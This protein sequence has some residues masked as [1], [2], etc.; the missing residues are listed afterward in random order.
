[1]WRFFQIAELWPVILSQTSRAIFFGSP[2]MRVVP[3]R[4]AKAGGELKS[5]RRWCLT[6][7]AQPE[8]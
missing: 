5:L 3:I 4:R 7:Q 1:L 2:A 8:D 6:T